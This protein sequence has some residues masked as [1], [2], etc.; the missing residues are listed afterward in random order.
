MFQVPGAWNREKRMRDLL[1]KHLR[2]QHS[3][4]RDQDWEDT[5]TLSS[6]CA[7]NKSPTIQHS[8]F[9]FVKLKD[10]RSASF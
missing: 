10:L 1:Q 3:V 2:K 5:M 4:M 9:S 8:I 6:V 7:M